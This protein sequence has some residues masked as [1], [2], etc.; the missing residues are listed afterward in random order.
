M[1]YCMILQ[2]YNCKIEYVTGDT[3]V[4]ADLL[5]RLPAKVLQDTDSKIEEP[6]VN[7]K[8]FEISALNSNRFNPKYYARCHV[9]LRDN[10]EKPVLETELDMIVEQDKEEAIA[11]LKVGLSNDKS[12]PAL[13]SVIQFQ[14]MFCMLFL[15]LIR[16]THSDSMYRNSYKVWY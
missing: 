16:I 1:G 2:G 12:S 4:S 7:D 6:D 11:E 10:L 8:A 9:D 15:M 5:S 3:I 13:Q 14:I